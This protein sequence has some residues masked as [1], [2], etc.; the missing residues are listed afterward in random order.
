MPKVRWWF[1]VLL[2]FVFA[3]AFLATVFVFAVWLLAVLL[4]AVT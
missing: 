1:I 4:G 3:V 2:A